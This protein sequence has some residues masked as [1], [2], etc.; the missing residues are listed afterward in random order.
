ME[1]SPA[2]PQPMP[3][4]SCR[5]LRAAGGLK[6]EEKSGVY[7]RGLP[8]PFRHT[9]MK[10][11]FQTSAAGVLGLL[12]LHSPAS[13]GAVEV[14]QF[15]S[16]D[17]QQRVE[18]KVLTEAADGGLL[19][20]AR[21][22]QIWPIQPGELV[23]RENRSAP[24][25]PLTRAEMTQSL[26]DEFGPGFQVYET[27]NYLICHSTTIDYVQWCERLFE[28]LH[29]SFSR[30]WSHRQ[31]ALKGAEFPLVALVFGDRDAYIEYGQGE[32]GPAIKDMI[33]FYSLQ[34]NRIALYDPLRQVDSDAIGRRRLST[35]KR[36]RLLAQ[37][38]GTMNVATIIHEAT[39]QLAFNSGL[40]RRFADNPLWLVEG[41]AVYFET[42]DLD[43]DAGWRGMGRVNPD[44]LAQFRDYA[45]NRRP[46]GAVKMLLVEDD[47]LRDSGTALDAYAEAWA[48]NYFLIRTRPEPYHAYLRTQ[49]AK[50]PLVHDTPEQRIAD[51]ENAFGDLRVLERSFLR[52]MMRRR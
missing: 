10:Q 13:A 7:L 30:Y 31:F 39:H 52:Y 48:L 32:A 20:L 12:V 21:D 18:G 6:A 14:V 42:P 51:F 19:L 50:R 8:N 37:L 34:T 44:R 23:A 38:T 29:R 16:G 5:A 47:R 46:A 28:R 1:T 45:A 33:G 40:H 26:K 11:I 2:R 36:D 35:R 9:S 22:G 17:R 24:F 27:N 49:R 3:H 15:R 43:S 41:M 25:V 4:R